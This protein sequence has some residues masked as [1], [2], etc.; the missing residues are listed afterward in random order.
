MRL[1]ITTFLTVDGVMQSPGGPDED[2]VGGF[3]LGG[4]LAPHF[5]EMVG[6]YMDQIFGRVDAFL[7]GRRTYD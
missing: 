6:E 3:D 2:R 4:W 5:D 7:F 1:T